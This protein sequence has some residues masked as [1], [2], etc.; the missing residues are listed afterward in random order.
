ML[1]CNFCPNNC[2]SCDQ[3]NSS[4]CL[5]CADGY[6]LSIGYTCDAVSCSISNCKHCQTSSICLQCIN[7]YY[8]D[9]A[10]AKCQ[11][12]ASIMCENGAEGPY[13]NQCNRK[14]SQY[15]Y[16]AQQVSTAIWCLP[17]NNIRINNSEYSQV[18]LYAYNNKLNFT[19]LLSTSFSLSAESTG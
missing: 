16:I 9:S 15:A 19:Q 14:C 7:G 11:Q 17:Y 10:Q 3:Y 8:W 2:L 13:P 4:R 1:T 5:S 18:Y 6:T 12:G